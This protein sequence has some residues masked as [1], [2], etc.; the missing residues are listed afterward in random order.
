MRNGSVKSCVSVS[1]FSCMSV[2]LAIARTPGTLYVVTFWKCV[3]IAIVLR[4]FFSAFNDVK[5]IEV[6]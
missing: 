5:T 3:Y 4:H 1:V 6:K 2:L